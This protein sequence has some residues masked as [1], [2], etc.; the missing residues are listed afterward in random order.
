MWDIS[1]KVGELDLVEVVDAWVYF[2]A[3]F[4]VYCYQVLKVNVVVLGFDVLGHAH[5]QDS[6]F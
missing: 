6:G 2:L 4:G 3:F 5:V 1:E